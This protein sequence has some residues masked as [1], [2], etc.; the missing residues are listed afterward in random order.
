MIKSIIF[1][2]LFASVTSF[3]HIPTPSKGPEE[4]RKTVRSLLRGRWLSSGSGSAINMGAPAAGNG[5]V[6]SGKGGT[7]KSVTS[8]NGKGGGIA[9][10]S[11]G[12][13]K[14]KGGNTGEVSSKSG[15]GGAG[16]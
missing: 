11:A 3:T 9:G 5:S 10:G 12:A 1:T 4:T 6:A 16:K 7:S 8:G 14:G 15:K 2:L 13:V